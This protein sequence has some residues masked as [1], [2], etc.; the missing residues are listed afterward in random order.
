MATQNVIDKII[1]NAQK[2]AQEILDR[3]TQNAEEIKENTQ[4]RIAALHDQHKAEAKVL[5]ETETTRAISQK[6]LEYNKIITGKKR[7]ITSRVIEQTL[8]SL[9]QH[10]DY[11]KFLTALI[12]AS[13]QIT[14]ELTISTED[15]KKHKNM[16]QRFFKAHDLSFEIKPDNNMLGGITITQGKKVFHGSLKLIAELLKDELTIAVS[17]ELF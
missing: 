9:P 7:Q 2:E 15:W 5:K 11:P 6:R 16:L 17:K 3:Y 1:E 10:K 4:A 12:Q 13:N 14:G 8:I